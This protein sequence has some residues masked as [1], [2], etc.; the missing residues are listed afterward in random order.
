MVGHYNLRLGSVLA[1]SDCAFG[2]KGKLRIRLVMVNARVHEIPSRP[3]A[4]LEVKC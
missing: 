3:S 4:I 2:N 1:P